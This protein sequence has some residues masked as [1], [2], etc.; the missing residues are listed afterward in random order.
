M[1]LVQH[2]LN[3]FPGDPDRRDPYADFPGQVVLYGNGDR[4]AH[5]PVGYH[6]GNNISLENGAEKQ[7]E[8]SVKWNCWSHPHKCPY[9][10]SP[11]QYERVSLEPAKPDPIVSKGAFGPQFFVVTIFFIHNGRPVFIPYCRKLCFKMGGG[12]SPFFW[13]KKIAG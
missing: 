2:G 3:L 11:C 10:N 6:C 5:Y 1:K 13:Q 9:P 8:A 7:G 4:I 12:N